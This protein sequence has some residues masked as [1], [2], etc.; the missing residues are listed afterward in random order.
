VP[1]AD[2]SIE[3]LSSG[4]RAFWARACF[5]GSVCDSER[6]F[7]SAIATIRTSASS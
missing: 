5:A 1:A 6:V 3:A 7:T 2:R 4:L